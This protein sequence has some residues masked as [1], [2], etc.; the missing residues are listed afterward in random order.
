ME[1]GEQTL[2]PIAEVP[3]NGSDSGSYQSQVDISFQGAAGRYRPV[4]GIGRSM[5]SY[6]PVIVFMGELGDF[7]KIYAG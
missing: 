4:T 1:G 5:S 7:Y 6:L 3:E 2:Q